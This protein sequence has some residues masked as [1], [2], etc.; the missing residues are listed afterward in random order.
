MS[1]DNKVKR[2]IQFVYGFSFKGKRTTDVGEDLLTV[3]GLDTETMDGRPL[4]IDS[5]DSDGN[6][7][8]SVT[9][10]G[11]TPDAF[12]Y[13]RVSED[14][15]D[16]EWMLTTIVRDEVKPGDPATA[17]LNKKN[18]IVRTSHADATTLT[19]GDNVEVDASGDYVVADTGDVVG[20][21][22]AT[23]GEEYVT[24]ILK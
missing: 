12:L 13:S 9:S 22:I 3:N 23:D 1:L 2:N 4:T 7:Q 15:T 5:V 20:R 14:L 16:A 21:V 8:V 11:A 18:G 19:A 6:I 17:V 10:A 24:I